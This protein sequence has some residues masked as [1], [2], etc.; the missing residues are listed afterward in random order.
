MRKLDSEIFTFCNQKLGSE[1]SEISTMSL[2]ITGAQS[3]N[4]SDEFYDGEVSRV[5]S[6]I[7]QK[8][9]WN[10]SNIINNQICLGKR[11]TYLKD[12]D[13]SAANDLLSLLDGLSGI[14]TEISDMARNASGGAAQLAAGNININVLYSEEEVT[15]IRT[16]FDDYSYDDFIALSETEK[17]IYERSIVEYVKLVYSEGLLPMPK[18]GKTTV[19]IAPGVTAYF[20]VNNYDTIGNEILAVDYHADAHN[21]CVH[22]LGSGDFAGLDGAFDREGRIEV[23][24]SQNIDECSSIYTSYGYNYKEGIY[25]YENGAN[26][27]SDSAT[28]GNIGV[29]TTVTMACGVEIS[30]P[31]DWKPTPE[32]V[33]VLEPE[34]GVGTEDIV[35]HALVGIQEFICWGLTFGGAA[36][37]L[38]VP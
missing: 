28:A 19:T 1:V 12:D 2:G 36:F 7:S 29:N 22:L 6:Q 26:F 21:A 34:L 32:P 25:F 31:A 11:N 30:A 18:Y 27:T 20:S 23:T 3:G 15:Y 38:V 24:H 13:S 4:S 5:Y 10:N 8:F 16:A 9:S 14:V 37:I 17:Y 33:P 35:G